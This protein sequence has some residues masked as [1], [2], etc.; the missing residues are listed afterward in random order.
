MN[1]TT[2]LLLSACAAASG[3]AAASEPAAVPEITISAERP[4]GTVVGHSSSGAQIVLDEVSYRLSYDDLDLATS[5]GADELRK[6]VQVAADSACKDLDKL[7]PLNK[8]DASCARK[9]AQNS[10]PQADRAISSAQAK[11]VAKPK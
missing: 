6:R 5:A 7:H 1:K 10:M 4:S 8:P 9:T 11:G 2:T 3:L